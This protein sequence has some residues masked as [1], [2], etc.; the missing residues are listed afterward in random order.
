MADPDTIVVMGHEF[1]VPSGVSH[2]TARGFI[3]ER[4]RDQLA[5]ELREFHS[6]TP[7]L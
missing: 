7:S 2:R 6:D 5:N 4:L 1:Q 3:L